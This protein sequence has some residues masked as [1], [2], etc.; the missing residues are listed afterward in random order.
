VGT[1]SSEKTKEKRKVVKIPN[2]LQA[3]T[4]F[5]T[6][7]LFAAGNIAAYVTSP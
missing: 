6:L 4:F 2:S 5:F 7:P 1:L 3:N